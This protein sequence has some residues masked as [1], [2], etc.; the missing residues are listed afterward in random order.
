MKGLKISRGV[1]SCTQ[2][3]RN[4]ERNSI[5]TAAET[6]WEYLVHQSLRGGKDLGLY[7]SRQVLAMQ[8]GGAEVLHNPCP[9]ARDGSLFLKLQHWRFKHRGTP[10]VTGK[11][12]GPN[13]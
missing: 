5:T 12:A 8:S 7:L 11:Q 1:C 10:R 4:R 2:L 13:L 3:K 6:L 9:E